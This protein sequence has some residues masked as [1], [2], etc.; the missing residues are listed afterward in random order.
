MPELNQVPTKGL[1]TFN[2]EG[3]N[4]PSSRYY[5]RRAHYPGGASG[6][7]IGR[8]YDMLK[9]TAKSVV[10]DLVA[11][12]VPQAEADS[13]SGGVG[14][15]GKNAAAFVAREDIRAIEI[16]EEA[17]KALFETVYAAYQSEARRLC[18][19]DDVTKK[20]GACDWD[21]MDEGLRELITDLHYRG[22]YSPGVRAKIQKALIAGDPD[23]IRKALATVGGVPE[24]RKRR[25]ERQLEKV[26]LK[27]AETIRA[28]M[29]KSGRYYSTVN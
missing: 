5:S 29:Q 1:L 26:A 2:A 6:V 22:D 16:S 13:L 3:D 9:R 24:D 19:K 4:E 15:S 21:K 17:Q 11:A 20:Y 12:G 23:A 25:R 7:T 27:R 18:T 10:A 14:L 8:G 28:W